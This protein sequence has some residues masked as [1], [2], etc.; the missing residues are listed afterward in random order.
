MNISRF[1]CSSS[2]I[3]AC[4]LGATFLNEVP[5]KRYPKLDKTPTTVGL[6]H[7]G[8]NALISTHLKTSQLRVRNCIERWFGPKSRLISK[9]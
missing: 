5:P 1:V 9:N 7:E 4:W 2:I 6:D 3:L 8:E